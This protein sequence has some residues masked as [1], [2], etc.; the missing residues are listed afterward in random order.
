M[1]KEEIYLC[2]FCGHDWREPC[3]LT[4]VWTRVSF[5]RFLGGKLF[6]EDTESQELD[7]IECESCGNNV[8]GIFNVRG[9]D[10]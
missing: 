7:K 10:V 6:E 3:A 9:F 8:L 2:P 1:S 5:T 4:L